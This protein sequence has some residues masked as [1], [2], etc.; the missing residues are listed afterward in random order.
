[1]CIVQGGPGFP[2]LHPAAY[3]YLTTG[4]Y[5]GQIIEDSDVPDPVLTKRGKRI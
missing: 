1:M 4:Q 5:M 2:M 3:K